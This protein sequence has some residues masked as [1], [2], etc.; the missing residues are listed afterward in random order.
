MSA[1]DRLGQ[2]LGDRREL[3]AEALEARFERF[4][5]GGLTILLHWHK[6]RVTGVRLIEE[7]SIEPQDMGSNPLTKAG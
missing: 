5:S 3:L 2:R 1:W 4:G 6:R 7:V